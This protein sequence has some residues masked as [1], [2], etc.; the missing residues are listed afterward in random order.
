MNLYKRY[1]FFFGL[2]GKSYRKY[3]TSSRLLQNIREFITVKFHP[4]G[5]SKSNCRVKYPEPAR[6]Q[7]VCGYQSGQVGVIRL[8]K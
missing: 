8:L 1:S 5:L 2:I 6:L 3:H 7:P 4:V